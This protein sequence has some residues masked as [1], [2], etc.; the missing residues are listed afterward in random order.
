ML[1]RTHSPTN[2]K[3]QI[4]ETIHFT[5]T[6]KSLLHDIPTDELIQLMYAYSIQVLIFIWLQASSFNLQA[7]RAWLSG[8]RR[9]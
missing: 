5:L 2:Y 8:P 1:M 6:L 9:P 3:P 7:G 4:N